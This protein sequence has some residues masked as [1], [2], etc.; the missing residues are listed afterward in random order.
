MVKHTGTDNI[1]KL[2]PSLGLK[3]QVKEWLLEPDKNHPTGVVQL[4]RNILPLPILWPSR[5]K[6]FGGECSNGNKYSHVYNSISSH[7]SVSARTS[8]QLNAAGRQKSREP[9]SIEV[10]FLG[11]RVGQKKMES[12]FR[13]AKQMNNTSTDKRCQQIFGRWKLNKGVTRIVEA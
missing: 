5:E 1:G 2:S 7:S 10:S 4:G 9:R 6:I 3:G 8:F 12:R 11:H 13:W